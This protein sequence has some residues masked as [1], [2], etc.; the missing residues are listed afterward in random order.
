MA[1]QYLLGAKYEADSGEVHP[2]RVQPETV[3][4]DNP[5]PT[6]GVSEEQYARARGSARKYGILARSATL[7]RVVGTG[8]Y[9]TAKVYA[10]I[11][12]FTPTALDSMVLGSTIVYQGL[13]W[14]VSSKRGESIR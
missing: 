4:E 8:N 9:G 7:S 14:V 10:R 1:G 6:G 11:P 5:Q 2:I 12:V 3:F 13:D